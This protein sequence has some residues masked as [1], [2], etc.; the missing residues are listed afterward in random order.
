[1]N[2]GH[3]LIGWLSTHFR[4]PIPPFRRRFIWYPFFILRVT[5]IISSVTSSRIRDASDVSNVSGAMM[6]HVY[7]RVGLG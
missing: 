6:L 2:I 5:D 1:M 7:I 4:M 3:W